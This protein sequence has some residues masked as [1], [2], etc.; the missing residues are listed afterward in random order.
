MHTVN[1]VLTCYI[2]TLG[3]STYLCLILSVGLSSL[4]VGDSA[5]LITG[6]KLG[7]ESS[8]TFVKPHVMYCLHRFNIFLITTFIILI[9]G[10]IMKKVTGA[11]PLTSRGPKRPCV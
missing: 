10:W 3:L 5:D 9:Q 7:Q 1:T 11:G 2:C 6:V 4:N 8:M